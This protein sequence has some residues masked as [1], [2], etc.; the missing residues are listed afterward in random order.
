M[1]HETE[2]ET[3]CDPMTLNFGCQDG[4]SLQVVVQK[5]FLD[6]MLLWISDQFSNAEKR[7]FQVFLFEKE[8]ES[9]CDKG[10]FTTTIHGN[11]CKGGWKLSSIHVKIL[12]IT[13]QK[14]D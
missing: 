10:L 5:E 4:N 8:A 2:A 7:L 12:A 3:A 11:F 13:Q 14:T 1:L 9:A 6:C